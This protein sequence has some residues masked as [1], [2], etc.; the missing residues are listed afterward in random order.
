MFKWTSLLFITKKLIFCIAS[1]FTALFS[2]Q[3]A[4]ARHFQENTWY[5][6]VLLHEGSKEKIGSFELE[7]PRGFYIS[8]H[9]TGTNKKPIKAKRLTVRATR[10]SIELKTEKTPY[11]SVNST[12]V[13]LAPANGKISANGKDYSGILAF[14]ISKSGKFQMI[15]W[16][17]LEEYIYSVLLSEVYQSWPVEMHK[18]QAIASRTYAAR[19]MREA[20][21]AG[22]EFDIKNNNFHQ[23]YR[24]THKY[25][26]LR[27]AIDQT[28]GMVL[29]YNGQLALT[30]FDACCGG[31]IPAKMR[32][33]NFKKTPYLSRSYACKYCKNYSLYRWK[34]EF[35]FDTL[36]NALRKH[37]KTKKNANSAGRLKNIKTREV[38]GAGVAHKV[39]LV[40]RKKTVTLNGADFFE[41][42]RH[43]AKSRSFDIS[44]KNWTIILSGR[45]FGHLT[46]LCQRGAREL[47]KRNWKAPK[48]LTFYYPG[49]VLTKL[50]V[51]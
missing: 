18:V 2:P 22:K 19:C 40:G 16:V 37:P 4:R 8:T 5:I 42:V 51:I 25:S 20:R 38:D 50:K 35:N 11:K 44:K 43:K 1:L 6:R 23:V 3:K 39:E 10:K 7:S 13:L 34:E 21:K 17:D 15:N 45:G 9:A 46:G 14:H 49:T 30:M 41:V 47:V 31:C 48:I 24:G 32:C 12:A 27:K 28:K 36:A 29:S 26:H 33:F